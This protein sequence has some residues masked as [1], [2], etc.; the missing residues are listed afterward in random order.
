MLVDPT[1]KWT[2]YIELNYIVLGLYLNKWLLSLF[3][4]NALSHMVY[5]HI[6]IYI[7]IYMESSFDHGLTV[8]YIYIYIH[9]EYGYEI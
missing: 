5:I 6:Y 8:C 1:I 2:I 3:W 9:H 4:F 7:H